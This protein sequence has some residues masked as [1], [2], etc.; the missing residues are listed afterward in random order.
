[1]LTA[2][3]SAAETALTSAN[4][5]R[6]KRMAK[7]GLPAAELAASVLEHEQW[8]LSALL[9]LKNVALIVAA[10]LATVLGLSYAPQWG[11]VFV[12]L[13]LTLLVLF[14]CRLLPRAWVMRDPEKAALVLVKPIKWLSTILYPLVWVF[15]A[16][17]DALLKDSKEPDTPKDAAEMEEELRL[18]IDAGEEE[19]YIEEDEREM[20]ASI[21][22]FDATLV[23]EIMVPRVDMVAL[24]VGASVN[25]ALDLIV[26]TGH[27][28]IPVYEDD[29]ENIAGILHAKDV[30]AHLRD[31]DGS[32][33]GLRDLLRPAHFVPETNKVGEVLEELQRE[34][35]QMAMVVDEYGGMAGVVTVE[36]AL[37]EIVGEI[38]D[39]Y[40]AVEPFSEIVNEKEA[41]FNARVDVDDVN[42]L[43]KT[44]L[45]TEE[46]DTLGGLIYSR[47]GGVPKVG[48]EFVLDGVRINVLSLLGRRIKKVR[49]VKDE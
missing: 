46:S 16:I 12:V 17:T 49:V 40:D 8:H 9:I 47:L 2:F 23:R 33:Q 21:F 27:S 13:S 34:R 15:R 48:D 38:E 24:H 11:S 26:E 31:N 7:E 14:L 39:E 6:V 19:G 32:Q 22:E 20:I 1:M 30:L 10:C 18:F 28:R 45:P 35:I 25:D 43:M 4:P 41:V 36:D 29:G 5:F 3:A 37:E 42:R 44:N